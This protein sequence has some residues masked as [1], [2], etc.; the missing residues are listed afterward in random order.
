MR[1]LDAR[2]DV[3]RNGV[4][5]E[6]L[7]PIDYPTI[8][9]DSDASIKTSLSGQFKYADGIDWAKDE[10]Q[11][12][13]VIDGVERQ[14]GV[15][16]P[17]TVTTEYN[18]YEKSINVE[19]YDRCWICQA[20]VITSPIYISAGSKYVPVIQ[21]MLAACGI[22]NISITPSDYEFQTDRSDWDIGTPYLKI[23]NQLLDEINYKQ[24]WFD[25]NGFAV[26][27]PDPVADASNLTRSYDFNNPDDL[28]LVSVKEKL[29][30]YDAPNKILVVCSNPDL[31]GPLISIAENK[32]EFSP[33]S[34][35]RRGRVISYVTQVNNIANQAA[36]DQYARLL[37]QDV[38]LKGNKVTLDTAILYG[39]G[40]RDIVSI[41]HPNIVGICVET[42]WTINLGT[43]G[44]MR[45]NL[46][47]VV[48]LE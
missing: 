14:L 31:P 42:G 6:T 39:C 12:V 5:F 15:F 4:R 24:L 48:T 1:T 23:I 19:A 32:N 36:L 7:T 40:V 41:V 20:N 47:K 43:G 25:Q 22:A 3:L 18:E 13:A 2:V 45:H 28:V 38:M 17:T 10:L 46:S 27:E 35:P 11:P 16:I 9:M 26:L 34:I 8:T 33:L 30:L 44:T 21:E 37:V 29:D